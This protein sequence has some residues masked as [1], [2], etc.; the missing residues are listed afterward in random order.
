M[1][2]A[3]IYFPPLSHSW[4]LS[5]FS[6]FDVDAGGGGTSSS[7]MAGAAAR[8]PLVL[9]SHVG[10]LHHQRRESFLYRSDSEYD[11]APSP[12]SMSRNS[13]ITSASDVG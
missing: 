3:K 1:L 8:A 4:S 10:G 5:S 9:Q 12:R 11:G 7:P 13:S 2:L 6:S